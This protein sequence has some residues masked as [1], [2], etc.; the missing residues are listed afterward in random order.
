MSRLVGLIF[1]FWRQASICPKS[2]H[3]KKRL[4]SDDDAPT[5]NRRKIPPAMEWCRSTAYVRRSLKK[6]LARSGT[7]QAMERKTT[8][9]ISIAYYRRSDKQKIAEAF[10]L[11]SF[12]NFNSGTTREDFNAVRSG[13]LW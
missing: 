5:T 8:Y 6:T 13:P 2:E 11:R 1:P 7:S 9:E 10:P 12:I 4:R 3:T